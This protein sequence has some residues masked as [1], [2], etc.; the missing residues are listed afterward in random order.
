MAVLTLRGS[1]MW[2][3]T[4]RAQAG[5]PQ[6]QGGLLPGRLLSWEGQGITEAG[7]L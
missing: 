2:L 4:S 7:S 5:H 1:P 3:E 6:S